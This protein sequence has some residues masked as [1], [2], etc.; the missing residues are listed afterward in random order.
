[1]HRTARLLT[2]LGLQVALLAGLAACSASD[3]RPPIAAFDEAVT[4]GGRLVEAYG[5]E[6]AEANFALRRAAI[7]QR[8][9]SI[10]LRS[11][12]CRPG[13]AAEACVLRVGP[14]ATIMAAPAPAARPAELAAALATYADSLGQVAG[15][16]T[17]ADFDRNAQKLT[18]AV[19]GLGNALPGRAAETAASLADPAGA[20]LAAL[21]GLALEQRRFKLLQGAINTADPA[22]QGA[23]TA[24]A[25]VTA[26]QREQAAADRATVIARMVTQFNALPPNAGMG[27]GVAGAPAV[28]QREALLTRITQLQEQQRRLLAD[29][30]ATELRR[31][32]EAHAALRRGVNDPTP[33]VA[34]LTEQL[35]RLSDRLRRAADAAQRLAAS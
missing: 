29:D 9:D 21:G 16:T 31:L 34:Q 20:L 26:G 25:E 15:A 13:A 10:M 32:G 35:K 18:D 30:P 5:R 24:L 3:F 17:E 28:V 19:R 33:P 7:A 23:A 6:R 8:Q 1:M 2:L 14:G 4:Q 12:D 22:V 27:G 11:A